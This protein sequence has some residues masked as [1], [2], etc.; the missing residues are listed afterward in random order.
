[1]RK[2][3]VM[4]GESGERPRLTRRPAETRRVGAVGAE[5]M[6]DAAVEFPC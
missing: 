1:M 6:R 3:E 4:R 2:S 5:I